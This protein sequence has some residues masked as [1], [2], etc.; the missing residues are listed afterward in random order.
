MKNFELRL[1]DI[2][3]HSSGNIET[4]F[5][6]ANGFMGIRASEPI[7]IGRAHV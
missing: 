4:L 3:N 7:E 1:E 6:Q 5:A 2:G